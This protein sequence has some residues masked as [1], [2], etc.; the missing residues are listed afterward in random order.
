[1][2]RKDAA[3]QTQVASLQVKIVAEDKF[4]ESQTVELLNDW[5]KGRNQKKRKL[6]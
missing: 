4:V 6:I 1:M 2:R 5:E 3:I